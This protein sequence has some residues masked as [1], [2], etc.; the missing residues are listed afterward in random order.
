MKL[1]FVTAL[2]LI[3]SLTLPTLSKAN[4]A[5][6]AFQSLGECERKFVQDFLKAEGYYKS[7]IDGLWGKGTEKAIVKFANGRSVTNIINRLEKC[8]PGGA[9]LSNAYSLTAT[10]DKLN[11]GFY[12]ANKNF[13]TTWI[14]CLSKAASSNKEFNSWNEVADALEPC[15]EGKGQVRVEYKMFNKI[16]DEIGQLRSQTRK[17]TRYAFG[18]LMVCAS[19]LTSE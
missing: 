9:T 4:E 10:S 15:L 12:L 17:M 14:D 16:L 11:S 2:A 7:S 13:E 18:R 3:V 6:S 5:K 19:K 8:L 1:F